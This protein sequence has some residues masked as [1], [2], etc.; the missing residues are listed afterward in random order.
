MLRLFA[1]IALV[2]LALPARAEVDEWLAAIDRVR[3]DADRLAARLAR[4]E[5]GRRDDER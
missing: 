5:R 1:T 3:V 4:L 2:A